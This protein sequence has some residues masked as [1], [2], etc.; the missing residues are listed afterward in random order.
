MGT[1]SQICPTWT[2]FNFCPKSGWVISLQLFQVDNFLMSL[3][4]LRNSKGD[5]CQH[6]AASI[7][8]R[9]LN[10]SQSTRL[11]QRGLGTSFIASGSYRGWFFRQDQD[12]YAKIFQRTQLGALMYA[13][14]AYTSWCL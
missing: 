3:H 7:A 13:G 10:S 12:S 14:R 9:L 2:A 6:S 1:S 4:L 11:L 8:H 5:I